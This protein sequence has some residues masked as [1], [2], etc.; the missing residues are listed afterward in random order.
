MFRRAG[1]AVVPRMMRSLTSVVILAASL[2]AIPS[3][4]ARRAL[5][6]GI[7]TIPLDATGEIHERVAK[8]EMGQGSYVKGVQKVI[9]PLVAVAFETSAQ[10]SIT[11]SNADR[12][13]TK[14]L[15]SHLLVDEQVLQ[16]IADQMQEIVERELKAQG[17]DVL[18]R[19]SIDAEPR[20]VGIAKD[21]KIGAEVKDN[22][23]SG[24]AGNGTKNRW[25]TA[26][27][28]ALFGI[29]ATA[30]LGETSALIRT[31]RDRGEAL[32][33]YRF[34]V[35]FADI[36]AKKG[37][38]F[39]RV[40]GK[41]V[42]HVASADLVVF[43]PARTNGG[44]IKLKTDVTAGADFVQDVQELPKE[45]AEEVSLQMG[46]VLNTLATGNATTA[47]SGKHSGHYAVIANP[48]IYSRDSLALLTAVSRQFA[49]ALHDAQ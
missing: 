28:R 17:F 44:M 47:T 23:M 5:L 2:A 11:H 13:S 33:F 48:E 46:A 19:E 36:D 42:L 3:A 40:K 43:S 32:L 8:P 1:A 22:F 30:A 41:N 20:Y 16:A 25:F 4:Q 45:K 15:E 35:Q 26:G 37:V 21:E 39:S 31:A 18:P 10:A 12:I 6:S 49:A 14:S 29:G 9:V 7:K 24:F 34:K 27:N 38:F